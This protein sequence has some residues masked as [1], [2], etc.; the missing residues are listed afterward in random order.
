MFNV[1][2]NHFISNVSKETIGNE[3]LALNRGKI[4][5]KL[6]MSKKNQNKRFQTELII[7]AL[8]KLCTRELL[9]KGLCVCTSIF[10]KMYSP[11]NGITTNNVRTVLGFSFRKFLRVWFL[12]FGQ[13]AQF[14]FFHR[15]SGPVIINLCSSNSVCLSSRVYM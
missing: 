3:I 15:R 10:T 7:V 1:Y 14:F 5:K 12:T 6:I 11:S 9:K 4:L 2:H 8:F 13:N